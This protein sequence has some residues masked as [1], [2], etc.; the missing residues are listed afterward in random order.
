MSED[1]Q[2]QTMKEA[3]VNALRNALYFHYEIREC[4]ITECF[5]A[6]EVDTFFYE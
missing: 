5:G 6:Q 4:V 2:S 3:N 1:D